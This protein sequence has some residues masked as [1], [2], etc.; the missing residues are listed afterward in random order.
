MNDISS[1]QDQTQGTPKH[2][3]LVYRDDDNVVQIYMPQGNKE[4]EEAQQMRTIEFDNNCSMEVEQQMVESLR[5]KGSPCV[6]GEEVK[7]PLIYKG[8]SSSKHRKQWNTE[9]GEA[10]ARQG[11]M[12]KPSTLKADGDFCQII[13]KAQLVL[14]QT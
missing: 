6:G 4:Y 14:A 9:R 7:S 8:S 12:F 13:Q 2:K 11:P 1:Y 10:G 3:R 5:Q